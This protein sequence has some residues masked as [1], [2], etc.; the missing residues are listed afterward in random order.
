MITL[1]TLSR[2]TAMKA[3]QTTKKKG[4]IMNLLIQFKTTK[5]LRNIFLSLGAIFALVNRRSRTEPLRL[6]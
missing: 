6:S 3:N 1:I 4:T 5:I 2:L